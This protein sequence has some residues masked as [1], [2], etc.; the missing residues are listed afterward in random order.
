MPKEL[1]PSQALLIDSVFHHQDQALWK[2][3]RDRLEQ[4]DRR[5]ALRQVSGIADEGL[6]DRLIELG[7]TPEALAA[8]SVVPL[9]RVAWADGRVQPEEVAVILAAARKAGLPVKDGR[10]PLLEH[11]LSTRPDG[12]LFAAWKGYLADLHQRLDEG[13]LAQLKHDLLELTRQ[14]A[15]AAGGF[16]GLG[17]KVSVAERVALAELEQAFA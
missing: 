16:L 10:Y 7:I 4:A 2:A 1:L 15:E 12:A 3:F 11:W 5:S 13:Q 17:R 8:V 9:V 6:L 14:V